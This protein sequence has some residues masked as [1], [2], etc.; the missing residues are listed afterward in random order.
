MILSQR[1]HNGAPLWVLLR[2]RRAQLAL[3][4]HRNAKPA[5]PRRAAR[6]GKALGRMASLEQCFNG[7]WLEHISQ[8]LEHFSHRLE[9]ISH[10]LETVKR[11]R[12]SK[13]IYGN[14]WGSNSWNSYIYICIYTL[15]SKFHTVRNIYTF[16]ILS[17]HIHSEHRYICY[18]FWQSEIESKNEDETNQT[19]RML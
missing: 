16:Q 19:R 10:R 15:F 7:Q 4:A 11:I 2:P 13:I 5:P 6:R 1:C 9:H 18:I 8:R 14:W 3:S 12:H 17:K